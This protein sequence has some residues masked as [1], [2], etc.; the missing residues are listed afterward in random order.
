MTSPRPPPPALSAPGLEGPISILNQPVA[1]P[2]SR[3]PSR[4]R[5]YRH[6]HLEIDLAGGAKATEGAPLLGRLEAFLSEKR[7]VEAADLL[8]LTAATL[9]ALSS[10]RFR[11]I[12]HWEV[13]PGGW[14]PPPAR[15][16]HRTAG[17]PVGDL[18]TALESGG[19]APIAKARSFSV[20]LSDRR[21]NHADVVVRRVHRQRRHALSLDLWGFWTRAM[22]DDLKGSLSARLPVSSSA[23][24][25]FQYA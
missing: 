25:R 11:W 23:L 6:A 18:L 5:P 3:R 16:S 17:T 8:R 22:V 4:S 24:T 19:W 7:I 21:G 12:D 9:H 13:E 15:R 14:L 10:V 20:R 1:G 2:R